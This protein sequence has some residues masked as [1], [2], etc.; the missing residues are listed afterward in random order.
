MRVFLTGV[1]G[2]IGAALARELAGR[3]VQVS[4]LMRSPA[5]GNELKGVPIR[6]I[7][8]D[9]LDLQALEQGM[10]GC[11]AVYHLAAQAGVWSKDSGAFDRVN[12]EGTRRVL[13]A[14]VKTGVQR[15]VF[16]ST[17]G[18]MGPSPGQGIAVHETTNPNPIMASA[19]ERSKAAA[20]SLAFSY[21]KQGLDVVVVNPTRIYGPGPLNESNSVAK[22]ADQFRRGT[23]R[24]IPGNGESI[25]NYVYLDDVV[26]GH[27]SAMEKGISGERYILGGENASYNQLFDLLREL[28][29]QRQALLPLPLPVMMLFAGWEHAMAQ[30]FGKKPLIVPEFVRKLAQNWPMSSEKA[31]T[32]LGYQITPLRQGMSRTLEWL[33]KGAGSRD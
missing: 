21:L 30:L 12:V 31:Q 17:G 16:T 8:G 20:E 33:E 28:T 3:G 32:A 11:D 29:G 22:L 6:L 18:V 1:T 19:Y 13:D 9:V 7:Q 10:H 26:Q 27:I 25:G 4:A 24:I 2:F 14:A 5:K 23:W 15:L